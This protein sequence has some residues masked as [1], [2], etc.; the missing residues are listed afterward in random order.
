MIGAL[1]L[2]RDAFPNPFAECVAVVV[3]GPVR[4]THRRFD[5]VSRDRRTTFLIAALAPHRPADLGQTFVPDLRAAVR[6]VLTS[7]PGAVDF[8]V[9]LTGNPALDYDVRTI[10][11]E[12][13]HRSEERVL[14]M[15]SARSRPPARRWSPPG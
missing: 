7:L 1:A 13:T 15:R 9:K 4:W 10:S 6:D 8:D 12:D 14:P 3:H 5:A 2:I 11:A